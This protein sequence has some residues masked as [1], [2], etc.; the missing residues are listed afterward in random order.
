MPL[1]KSFDPHAVE[2]RWYARWESAGWFAASV[3]SDKPAYTIQLPPPN[4]TG[5]LHMGHAFQQTLMDALIRYH[6]MRGFNS[7]WVIGTD[8]AGIATQIVVERQLEQEGKTRRDLGREKFVERVWQWKQQSGSTI[9]RQMRRLGVSGNWT[10][11][12][13][14]GQKA[15][16]FTMDAKMSRAVVEVFVRLYEEG[17]IY[18]GKR[19]VNWDPVLGTAVSDLEVDTDEE[20]GKIW[21]IRYPFEDGSG[22]LAVATTRP[23][24]ML[25]DV[26]VAVNPKDERYSAMVGK[27]L[28]LPLTG[29]SI[30]VIADDAVDPAF[31]T[32][33]VKVTPA[34][35]FNDWAM[36]QRHKLPAV[37][38]LTLEA[39]IQGGT[40]YDGLDRF[41]ARKKVLADLKSQDLLVSEKPYRLRLPRSGRT[42][43]IVEPMLTD[44]WFVKMEGLA[45]RGLEAVA[46]GEVKFY[47]EHWTTT[48]NQWLEKIQD[49]CISRQLW[50]GHQIPAWYGADGKIYVGRSEEEVRAKHGVSGALTRDPDVLDTWFSSALVP[51]SSLGWP[52]KTKDLETFLPSSVL[53]TGFDIIFFWVARM[54]MMTLHFTGK[55]PFRDVYINAIVRDAE[56]QKMSKSKGNTLDPLDLIDGI[57]LAD[58]VAKSTV[59]LLRP[60]QRTRI[61]KYAK[62]HYPSG[63]PAFGTDAL[64]FTFASLASFA[65]TLNFDL[66]RCEGYRNFNNKLWNATRFVLMNAEGKDCGTDEKLPVS[67]SFA[68]R[69]II[70]LLQRTEAEVEKGFAEYRFD[71]VA[72]AIYRFIWDEYCD[73]YVEL[74][75]VQL[76]SSDEAVQ[77][78]T[79]RT[80]VRVLETVLRLA[81]PL[82]PFIT[83]ELWQIVAPLAGK[84]GET[85]MLAPYPR[86]Q[87]EKIDEDA[88]RQVGLLKELLNAARALRSEMGIS[89]QQKL[90]LY[91]AGD[92]KTVGVF[93]PY[94]KP[95]PLA[96]LSDV[97]AVKDL[98]AEDAPVA[99]VGEFRLML[100]VEVDVAAERERLG[101]EILRL[102]GEIAKSKAKLANESFVA[103]APEKIV[104]QERERLAGFE[105]TLGEIRHQ[106]GKLARG[107]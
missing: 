16:Y 46:R 104:A 74:A 56:G 96:H 105:A 50:W 41:E 101:K 91:V 55:V 54:I 103:R 68:D 78:G 89:P 86:S 4:V 72:G 58:L 26:A 3:P 59:G 107:G 66:N 79:R 29:R 30:P 33:C 106:V 44:Q 20:D 99:V 7:N 76:Q 5:T 87:P 95:K 19:L 63:I 18:R 80:L 90:P 12:D 45:K 83:E 43:V 38:I 60:E 40:K 81:H 23:E 13:T 22:S 69:W 57:S 8:H 51:F 25:G 85:V 32:G 24:T 42:G 77:R 1:D 39:K 11:A 53:V 70:S 64:R 37:E 34:H 73:W 17:L 47:P 65:R 92:A 93:A 100:H 94:L 35:D 28:A 49:W 10:Y 75:K 9:T 102:E 14:E 98:P 67:L 48:Y 88:E 21:E 36:A 61:E 97:H 31:G 2:G 62:A 52:E 71:N 82:I 6:R 27:K 84:T 15:G